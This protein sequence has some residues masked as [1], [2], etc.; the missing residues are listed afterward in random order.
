MRMRSA[1]VINRRVARPQRMWKSECSRNRSA[2]E[3]GV[4]WKWPVIIL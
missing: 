2:V 1:R 3:I 4:Q